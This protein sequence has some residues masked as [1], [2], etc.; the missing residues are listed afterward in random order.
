MVSVVN[1][2]F[3]INPWANGNDNRRNK[4]SFNEL[5]SKMITVSVVLNDEILCSIMKNEYINTMLN[6][7][8]I[9]DFA[10]RRR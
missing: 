7:R 9:N 8:A 10:R 5:Y 2:I 6:N 3:S 1:R 4:C